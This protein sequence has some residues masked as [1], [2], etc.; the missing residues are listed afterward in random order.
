MSRRSE[1]QD[2]ASSRGRPE[3]LPK[4]STYLGRRLMRIP[5]NTRVSV[6]TVP[7]RKVADR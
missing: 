1:E 4:G 6:R 5:A 2:Q 3:G 7:R